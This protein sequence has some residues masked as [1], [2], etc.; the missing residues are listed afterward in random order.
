MTHLSVQANI[1]VSTVDHF[2]IVYVYLRMINVYIGFFKWG[3]SILTICGDHGVLIASFK[4]LWKWVLFSANV[5]L[6]TSFLRQMRWPLKVDFPRLRGQIRED[7]FTKQPTNIL[8]WKER[9][10]DQKQKTPRQSLSRIRNRLFAE[11]NF[12]TFASGLRP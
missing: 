3:R 9:H 8:T 2:N 7:R 1:R 4:V 10:I 5:A 6:I 11:I 12:A